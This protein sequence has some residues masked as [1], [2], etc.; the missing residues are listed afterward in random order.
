MSTLYQ[1][2][3]QNYDFKGTALTFKGKKIS[4]SNLMDN[5]DIFASKLY[6]YGIRKDMVVT[7][8]SPN[9]PETIY[10]LYAL[11]KIGAIVLVVHPLIPAKTLKSAMD[12]T[13]SKIVIVPDI[14]ASFYQE[15]LKDKDMLLLT[16][17]YDLKFPIGALYPTVY[18]KVLKNI[19][20]TKYI[21]RLPLSP[22]KFP[23]NEDDKKA[24]IYLRSGGTTGD[25]K[26]IVLN[27]YAIN[28]IA[29]QCFDILEFNPRQAENKKMLAVLPIFHGFG[30]AMGV[31]AP[32]VNRITSALMLSFDPKLVSKMIRKNELS[33]IILIP[34]MARKLLALKGFK[35]KG[36]KNLS[37]AFI[38]GDKVDLKI[39]EEFDN[40]MKENGSSCILMEG[41][42][43]TEVVTVNT[44]N[45]LKKRK[46]GS[47]GLPLE[48]VKIRITDQDGKV[49]GPNENG[50]IELNSDMLMLGYL[51]DEE[52]TKKVVIQDEDGLKWLRT[53][54]IGMLDSDGYLFFKQRQKE[55]FKIAGMNVF[56]NDIESRALKFQDVKEAAA[57][58]FEKTSHSYVT[59]FLESQ[60][61]DKEKLVSQVRKLLEDELIKYSVPEKIIV[62][63]SFPRTNVGKIDRK[64]LA[65]FT[66]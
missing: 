34:Y 31:H 4:Y 38:G 64:K 25:S 12:G 17:K 2:I 44:V 32:L 15:E 35:G 41:Y 10:S 29:Y 55:V 21:N 62:L 23:I 22:I 14:R 51:N 20:K 46:V 60:T 37:H 45:T 9:I 43:L 48:G 42:G 26:T 27:D 13:G 18:H 66:D 40:R 58:F 59:L 47:V 3:N 1:S 6:N 63:E 11:N 30:L 57:I 39:F 5:V 53:G 24:S 36:L 50:N 7:L 56:P 49:L 8:V 33:F 65:D 54:D 52:T 16:P 61:E 19:D 28:R